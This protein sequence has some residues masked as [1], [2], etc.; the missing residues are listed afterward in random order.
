[1]ARVSC[2]E[3]KCFSSVLPARGYEHKADKRT[4]CIQDKTGKK[5]SRPGADL[6]DEVFLFR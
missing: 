4:F 1:M 5:K 2:H 3:K 6:Y